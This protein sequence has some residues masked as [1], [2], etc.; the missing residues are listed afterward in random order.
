M[1]KLKYISLFLVVLLTAAC[2]DFLDEE[3]EGIYTSETY[4]NDEDD[5]ISSVNGVYEVLAFT[6]T[7][8]NL[9][10]FGDVASDDAVKGGATGDQSDIEE[11]DEFTA[12][13]DNGAIENIWVH[14]FEGINRANN[15]IYYVP[16]I[17]M[18]DTELQD[19]IVAEAKFLRAYFYFNLVNIF[20]EIPLKTEPA[21]SADDLMVGLSSVD[22][23]Y[24]QIE[25][26]LTEAIEDLPDSY[27]SSETGR[28]TQ[29]AALG[30]LAKT[31]I[32]NEDWTDALTEIIALEA[33]G[34]YELMPV[35]RNNFEFDYENNVESIFEI[36]H[37]S[38]QDP[39]EGSYLN[40]WFSP[41][42]ENGYYFDAPTEDLVDEFE[43]N[44]EVNDPR[45]EYSIGMEG[46][47]WLNGED[48]DSSWST[49][50]YLSK[51]H[52]QP[53]DEISAGTKGDA[54]LNYTYM[55][56]ADILLLKAEAL[57]ELD[58][59]SEA[60]VPLN[61]VRTRA[62][63][64]Y[65]YD[66]EIIG[67]GTIPDDLLL[68]I[69]SVDQDEVRDY[70]RQERR[71]ELCLEFHRFFDLMRYGETVAEEALSDKDFDYEDDRYFPI[72]QSELDT[73]T[74]I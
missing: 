44:S 40:Q 10:V 38:G 9:W 23:I 60:L 73:N 66:D 58:R 26:D 35:Y 56:Y 67:Y 51:K 63:E 65:L 32:F 22:D 4:Y 64:S 68:D 19:R 11:V 53:L 41:S 21:L 36:Q 62:R 13:S 3:L 33:L 15:T 57:N 54:D 25:T 14:Y 7:D 6:D 45:A 30:L 48:F 69:T 42:D 43:S 31:Y 1:Y 39:T 16:Q 46:G 72:P 59:T 47:F 8:N 27:D 55:R 61:E 52:C 24:S 70:I 71:V 20:G 12:D 5:A 28:V 50:G 34:V 49:T 2:S 18:D 17:S 29:G 74:A 37:L